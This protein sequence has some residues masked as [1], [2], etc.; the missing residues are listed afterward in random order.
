MKS[1]YRRVGSLLLCVVHV[2]AA[3]IG[4]V[5]LS[6]VEALENSNLSQNK[7]KLQA[8]ISLETNSLD[9]DEK[10]PDLETSRVQNQLFANSTSLKDNRLKRKRSR[11]S[12][13]GLSNIWSMFLPGSSSNLEPSD[14][15]ESGDESADDP[16]S[17]SSNMTVSDPGKVAN[18]DNDS[19]ITEKNSMDKNP[20]EPKYLRP[21]RQEA[22]STD[23]LLSSPSSQLV[24]GSNESSKPTSS[25]WQTNSTTSQESGD[26][27][28][29]AVSKLDEG[30]NMNDI[31]SNLMNSMS[32]GTSS[33]QAIG[34][35]EEVDVRGPAPLAGPIHPS[36]NGTSASEDTTEFERWL[37][38]IRFQES[39][40]TTSSTRRPYGSQQ[41]N[42]NLMS[43][44]QIAPTQRNDERT[45]N[46]G[47]QSKGLSQRMQILPATKGFPSD[48]NNRRPQRQQYPDMNSRFQ[49]PFQ[50]HL[51]QKQSQLIHGIRYPSAQASTIS[52]STHGG[53]SNTS[54]SFANN[55]DAPTS[56]NQLPP[57]SEISQTVNATNH[58]NH[59]SN[60]TG[61]DPGNNQELIQQ[62]VYQSQDEIL[63]QVT[64]AINFEQQLNHK[65]REQ[66]HQNDSNENSSKLVKAGSSISDMTDPKVS[67]ISPSE[68]IKNQSSGGVEDI[69]LSFD[70]LADK[71]R[72]LAL[73]QQN[74]FANSTKPTWLRRPSLQESSLLTA[75]NSNSSSKNL[76]QLLELLSQHERNKSELKA[77]HDSMTQLVHQ[78]SKLD[79]ARKQQT[80]QA[81]AIDRQQGTNNQISTD[82]SRGEDPNKPNQVGP[83][84]PVNFLGPAAV[85]NEV[86]LPPSPANMAKQRIQQMRQPQVISQMK[87]NVGLGNDFASDDYYLNNLSM[88]FAGPPNSVANGISSHEKMYGMPIAV[89]KNDD[90]QSSIELPPGQLEAAAIAAAEQLIG[91]NK[92]TNRL[93][94]EVVNQS[95]LVLSPP[96]SHPT[97]LII[98]SDTGRGQQKQ[99]PNA[100]P[101]D[102]IQ[103]LLQ[104]YSPQTF[105]HGVAPR[106]PFGPTSFDSSR[107]RQMIIHNQPTVEQQIGR[108]APLSMGADVA[109]LIHDHA[110][111]YEHEIHKN[112]RNPTS[113]LN[114]SAEVDSLDHPN[115]HHRPNQQLNERPSFQQDMQQAGQ[116]SASRVNQ[117]L[118]RAQQQQNVLSNLN[119]VQ[120]QQQNSAN[121]QLQRQ[122]ELQRPINQQLYG[123][124]EYPT[125]VR[126]FNPGQYAGNNQGPLI[127]TTLAHPGLPV[128]IREV[129]LP[130]PFG[131]RSHHSVAYTASPTLSAIRAGLAQSASRPSLLRHMSPLRASLSHGQRLMAPLLQS[132]QVPAGYMHYSVHQTPTVPYSPFVNNPYQLS[133]F[134]RQSSTLPAE[135]RAQDDWKMNNLPGGNSLSAASKLKVSHMQPEDIDR[136][137]HQHLLAD[138]GHHYDGSFEEFLHQPAMEDLDLEHQFVMKRP[139]KK[140]PARFLM[141]H[142]TTS[143]RPAPVVASSPSSLTRL[144][145]QRGRHFDLPQIQIDRPSL[146]KIKPTCEPNSSTTPMIATTSTAPSTSNPT[147]TVP[148]SI[149]PVSTD[150]DNYH[151]STTVQP[152]TTTTTTMT[153]PQQDQTKLRD[154]QSLSSIVGG[155]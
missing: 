22:A 137:D 99:Q 59:N 105:M 43:R 140:P 85:R 126:E 136:P 118:Q 34:E 108:L 132:P 46:F 130:R 147:T 67:S 144:R 138:D 148:P 4:L 5:Q 125:T 65:K 141:K 77:S 121:L 14:Y 36:P 129:N 15:D 30:M 153:T 123:Y 119:N 32:N 50:R 83:W 69:D 18:L 106:A 145:Q 19:Q 146:P 16:I 33:N 73:Q 60:I 94:S 9:L 26:F 8:R 115:Y 7:T 75:A 68:A 61:S 11:S 113:H 55:S 2:L 95:P 151:A 128:R 31:V 64:S 72:I 78:L 10:Q 110:P 24:R 91:H 40:T 89:L 98:N 29:G 1:N 80:Q 104:Q 120:Q 38:K 155:I 57:V 86:R 56:L 54:L 81:I 96:Q 45:T 27:L 42:N 101:I 3:T 12:S 62:N 35:R 21:P 143:R 20:M 47:H 154:Q 92:Q 37:N 116:S 76:D 87:E 39:A 79:S 107:P 133:H 52:V 102:H 97:G 93:T 100:E 41:S 124:T 112:L 28:T 74:Q 58:H 111:L 139:I 88:V 142:Q 49:H 122:Q 6:V 25:P 103:K 71:L 48:D 131:F 66:E 82:L 53:S 84:T 44:K 13:A 117:D 134:R 109:S 135:Q 152:P 17:S 114:P 127:T 70:L 149:R 23:N 63:R 150:F 51:R 90:E